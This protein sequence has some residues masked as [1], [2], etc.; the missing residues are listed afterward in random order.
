[1]KKKILFVITKSN[2]GGAQ[3]YVYELATAASSRYDTAVILGGTGPLFQKLKSAGIRTISLSNLERDIKVISDILVFFELIKIFRKE[4]PHIIH[5]NSSKIG[6]LGSLAGRISGIQQIIF[7][8]HG[9][10]FNEARPFIQKIIIRLS[11]FITLSLSHTTILVSKRLRE[12]VSDFPFVQKKLVVIKNGV[13]PEIFLSKEDAREELMKINSALPLFEIWIGTVAELHPI[14]GLTYAIDA[15]SNVALNSPEINYVII[16]EGEE[17][18]KIEMLI[19]DKGLEKKVFLLGHIDNAL[20]YLKSL[21][22]FLLPSLSEG[23]GLS[24]LEAGLAALPVVA[25]AVG[26][27]PEIISDGENGIL[28]PPQNPQKI[29]A[30]LE[31]VVGDEKYRLKLGE[32]LRTT[33]QKDFS[34]EKMI[35][36]TLTLYQ[37]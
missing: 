12:D 37:S 9:W 33:V 13:G 31:R 23:L 7:T 15:F 2:W 11:V 3:K 32:N 10:A 17:R 30:A 8:G 26:G 1:M 29:I 27:I 5:L 18:K 28:V 16:G 19:K 6:G 14:K 25:S 4:R 35:A 22:I 21:D 24:L 36:A 34:L 20:K